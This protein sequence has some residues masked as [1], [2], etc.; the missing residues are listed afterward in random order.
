MK[1]WII[2][3]GTIGLVFLADE[4]Y[5]QIQLRQLMIEKLQTSQKLLEAIAKADFKQIGR[6]ADRLSAMV[7][8]EEWMVHK[9]AKYALYSNE[10]RRAAETIANKAK[11][12][13][14]DGVTLAYFDLTMSC[15][16]CHQYTREVRD[17]ALPVPLSDR[18][19]G[20]ARRGR[21]P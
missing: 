8:R 9:T 3:V 4:V 18:A 21:K 12:K 2:A 6:E 5:A 15:V 13:N 11:D 19:I 17:A 16:R 14:L 20:F 7:N 1:K 10:F